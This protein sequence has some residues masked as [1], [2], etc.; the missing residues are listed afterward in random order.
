MEKN[1]GTPL[2]PFKRN[3]TGVKKGEVWAKLF[4]YFHFR[5]DEF[6]TRYHRKCPVKGRL[7]SSGNL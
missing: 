3:S 4:H 7:A 2:I 5:R 1:G 6:L